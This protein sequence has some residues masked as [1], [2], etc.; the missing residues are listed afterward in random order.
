MGEW[1][2]REIELE[3]STVAH[4]GIFVARH[5]GRVIF[6]ADAIPGERVLA[7]ITDDGKKSFW[8]AETVAVLRASEHRQSHLWPEAALERAPE[9][10]A[11]GAEFGHIA[12]AHQRELKAEVLRDA[13]QRM[14]KVEWAGT[15][16]PVADETAD[17]SGWRTRLRLHVDENGVLGPYAA[18]S[19]TVIPVTSMPLATP[20]V[21][22]AIPFDSRF[23]GATSVD[24]VA[25]SLGETR[26]FVDR[27]TSRSPIIERVGVRD[28]QL[29]EGGFWQ[30]HRR[31][32][33]TL[34]RAVQDAIRPELFDPSADNLDLYG[35]VGLLAAAVADRFDGTRITSVE[36]E[37][38]ATDYAAENLSEWI[39]ARAETAQVEPYLRRQVSAGRARRGATIVLDPPRSGA[40]RAVVGLLADL[41]PAQLVYVACDPVALA[42]DVAFF[43][44]RGYTMTTVSA[45]DLF[46]NTHHFE[47]V[48][49][50]QPTG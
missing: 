18:R 31:A 46:P 40:G 1:Q 6:V 38:S 22:A 23:E 10:R 33:E 13:L 50:L 44:D 43:A 49:L 17:G 36:S 7:R 41:E 30:V 34:T 19:H 24:V 47:A 32:A 26:I 48:A 20:D 42:R 35:G 28:F 3:I 9:N 25:P 5:E 21:L 45:F 12:L 8:R 27:S 4:G 2:G 11:G 37:A 16:D 29:R 39:A 15:V 14:A